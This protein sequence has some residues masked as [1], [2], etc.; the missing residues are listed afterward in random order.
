MEES[1]RKETLQKS[2]TVHTK[3]PNTSKIEVKTLNLCTGG[4]LN[5]QPLP[6]RREAEIYHRTLCNVND[7]EAQYGALWTQCQRCQVRA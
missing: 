7:M 5:H 3:S 4:G 1:R 2:R 6:G